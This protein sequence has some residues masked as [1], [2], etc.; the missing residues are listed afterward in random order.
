MYGLANFLILK[1]IKQAIGLDQSR[2]FFYGAAPLKQTSVDYFA[3]LDIPLFNMYGLSETAG[4]ATVSYHNDFSLQHA[5]RQLSGSHIKIADQDE[6]GD[7]EIR[8]FGRHIMMGYL[9][10]DEATI[11]TIDEHG[12]FKTGD[13]G[14]IEKG[15]F[16]KITGRIKELIITAG[17]ENVAPVPI[18]DNFKIACEACSN[19]MLLGENQRFMAA[20]IT[21]KVDIDMTTGLPSNKLTN[22]AVKFIKATTGEELKTSDEACKNQKVFEMIQK[23]V[24]ET[25]SKSVSKAAHLKKF[26]LLPNDFSQPGGELTPTMKLKRKVTE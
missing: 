16:L 22:E 25:N 2:F 20:L 6:K 23:C 4:S 5:G 8:V 9:K 21:F 11:D 15:G 7:G 14:R 24:N 10:N 17:G 18:E 19:I 13:Q 12:Y 3:S 26:K 1:R